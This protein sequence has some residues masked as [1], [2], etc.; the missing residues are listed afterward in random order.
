MAVKLCFQGNGRLKVYD[1][2]AKCFEC[3][4][5]ITESRYGKS[6]RLVSTCMDGTDSLCQLFILYVFQL[7]SAIRDKCPKQYSMLNAVYLTGDQ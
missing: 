4:I 1:I 5:K 6:V 7:Y 2:E 3:D